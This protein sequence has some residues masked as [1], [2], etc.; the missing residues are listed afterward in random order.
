MRAWRFQLVICKNGL[1]VFYL[2]IED[3]DIARS[4]KV[5]YPAYRRFTLVR[6]NMAEGRTSAVSTVHLPSERLHIYND[7][8]QIFKKK[9]GIPMLC[10]PEQLE[11]QT[12]GPTF[13]EAATIRQSLQFN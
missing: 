1:T 7:I 6:T 4:E 13:R 8:C 5:H 12:I 10:T 11:E 3:T 2:K 9:V